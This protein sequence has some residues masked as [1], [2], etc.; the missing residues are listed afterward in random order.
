MKGENLMLQVGDRVQV[1][2][3]YYWYEENRHEIGE[4]FI[5]Q[6]QHMGHNFEKFVKLVG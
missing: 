4:Q 3:P 6:E 1:I 5:I 2:K